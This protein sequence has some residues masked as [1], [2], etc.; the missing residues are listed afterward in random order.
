MNTKLQI[1]GEINTGHFGDMSLAREAVLAAKGAGLDVIKFQSWRPESLYTSKYLEQ[2]RLEAG[3]YK[4]FSLGRDDLHALAMFSHEVGIGFSSTPYS[5]GEVE[6]LA[7]MPNLAFIKVASMEV[8]NHQF[9]KHVAKMSKPIVLST[10]MSTFDE[11]ELAVRI[12]LDSAECE[13]TLLHCTSVYPTPDEHLNLANISALKRMF[14]GLPVGYSD[15]SEGVEAGVAAVAF[16]AVLLE[17]HFTTSKTKIGFD[18]AMAMSVDEIKSYVLSARRSEAMIGSMERL[19][20]DDE[21]T[22]KLKMRRSLFLARSVFRGETINNDSLVAKRPGD[23]IGPSELHRV[24]GKAFTE[25]LTKDDK[26]EE[27]HFN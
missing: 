2:N 22:Q 14:P 3:L 13:L 7:A 19:L 21:T 20:S 6:E 12:I 18:N 23:G 9:L 27:W 10:G 16:G 11:I 1:V 8:N 26:L 4:R 15:H 17:K 5:E 24:V 25:D